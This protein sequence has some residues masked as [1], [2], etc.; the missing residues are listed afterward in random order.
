MKK[1]FAVLTAL[2]MLFSFTACN[3]GGETKENET[4]TT[5]AADSVTEDMTD[6]SVNENN[7][8]LST[9]ATETVTDAN[10]EEITSAETTLTEVST[11]SSNPADWTKE[12]IVAFYRNAAIKSKTKVKSKEMKELKEMVVN[13][14]D[15]VLGTLVEWVTPFLIKALEDSEVEFDGIT[16][17]YEKLVPSDVKSAKAYKSG[18]YTVIEMTMVE[19]TDGIHDDRYEGTVGHAISVVGDI[20]SVAEALSFLE[21][22]FE[23][24]DIKLHYTQPKLKVKINKD[25]IIEKGTWSYNIDI[26][27]SNLYVAAVKFPIEAMVE[28]AHGNVNYLITVGGGF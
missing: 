8:G 17:G 4:S 27:V 9:E 26:T 5:T 25:G 18:D 13:D 14:G 6:I 20:S 16:G 1:I 10:G 28:S 7:D 19:Q 24:A 22:D 11:E 2:I 21:I 15:G 23:N 12:Q 3:N